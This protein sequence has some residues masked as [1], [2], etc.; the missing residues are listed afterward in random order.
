MFNKELIGKMKHGAHLVNTARGGI[1]DREAVV[2]ALESGQLAGELPNVTAMWWDQML[3]SPP[4][5]TLLP[6]MHK[7]CSQ[8]PFL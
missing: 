8:K 2:E 5:E 3:S 6:V 7:I 1:C 4:D